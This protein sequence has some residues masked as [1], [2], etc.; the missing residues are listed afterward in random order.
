MRMTMDKLINY[1][2]KIII[3]YYNIVI[4]YYNYI[5]KLTM[6]SMIIGH[7]FGQIYI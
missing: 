6:N 3:L 4:L 1:N 2:Y 7:V 5:I